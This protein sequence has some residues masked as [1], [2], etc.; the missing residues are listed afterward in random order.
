MTPSGTMACI[1][2]KRAKAVKKL[3]C[4][5]DLS[6]LINGW[7]VI[8]PC[9]RRAT[10]THDQGYGMVYLHYLV[11]SHAIIDSLNNVLSTDYNSQRISI[12]WHCSD[13]FHLLPSNL[14][15][16]VNMALKDTLNN[17]IYKAKAIWSWNLCDIGECPLTTNLGTEESKGQH[18]PYG[19]S[20]RRYVSY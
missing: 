6:P 7:V 5:Q 9:R 13:S 3:H 19:D 11:F 2:C 20:A 4:I 16:L 17:L 1:D 8:K 14:P 15:H 10:M 12:L 18:R